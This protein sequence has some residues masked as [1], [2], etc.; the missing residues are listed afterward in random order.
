MNETP[1]VSA[2]LGC[3]QLVLVLASINALGWLTLRRLPLAA[4]WPDL[5]ALGLTLLALLLLALLAASL[6]AVNPEVARTHGGVAA[7]VAV[8]SGMLMVLPFT[9]LA[10]IAELVLGWSAAQAF[11][12]AGVMTGAAGVGVE[13]SRLG[14]PKLANA[15]LPALC[16]GLL[17]AAWIAAGLLLQGVGR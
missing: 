12:T 8:S 11:A 10:L 3:L 17:V 2:G 14:P 4:P 5:A 1:R 7:L 16:G 9:V 13:M 6:H 15:L